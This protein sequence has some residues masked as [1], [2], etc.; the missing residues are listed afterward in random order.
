MPKGAYDPSE[1]YNNL[2]WVRYKSASWVCKKN[3]VS[4]VEPIEG[5][6]WT[7][8]AQDIGNKWYRGGANT[9]YGKSTTPTVFTT[10]GV[11]LAN[12]GDNFMNIV[13]GAIYYCVDGGDPTVATWSYDFSLAGGG[14]G[15]SDWG[16]LLN[17]PF[18]NVGDGLVVVNDILNAD[19]DNTN[20]VLDANKKLNL[21]QNL[22]NKLDNF[23]NDG[24]VDP[25]SDLGK[26]LGGVGIQLLGS[27]DGKFATFTDTTLTIIGGVDDY[28]YDIYCSDSKRYIKSQT[29]TSNQLKV[30]FDSSVSSAVVVLVAIKKG[31]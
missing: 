23:Q 5:D 11:N 4:G 26:S 14:G 7:T 27:T 22:L 19:V 29:V 30:E 2:D 12:A 31:V 1:T 3:N 6:T 15:V 16:D 21:H 17:K 25:A 28:M 8:L 13:E 18:T 24:K 10:S 9:V 20:V